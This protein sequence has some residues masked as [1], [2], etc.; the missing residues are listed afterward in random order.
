MGP[1]SKLSR[2]DVLASGLAIAALGP[3]SVADADVGGDA[4]HPRSLTS[5]GRGRPE[6]RSAGQ[7]RPEAMR[8]GQPLHGGW[9]QP[10]GGAGRGAASLRQM[11]DRALNLAHA[12]TGERL[13]ASYCRNGQY[14]GAAL[15][16]LSYFLRDWRQDAVVPIDPNVIDVMAL[17]QHA[18][19][20]GRPL[21]IL[22]GYRTPSTNEMLA[23]S[24]PDV[25]RNS[26]HLRG[27]AIDLTIPGAPTGNLWDLARSLGLGG[28]GYYP[29]QR[30]IHVDSG[31]VR[32]WQS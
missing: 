5:S 24:N 20:A 7:V 32:Y 25:A 17:I 15:S 9:S 1:G 10:G 18:A 4:R 3:A 27:M 8:S 26:Y 13:T 6:F 31:P 28:V 22:S 16:Q 30:F 29:A 14:D 23:R 11:P 12:Q 2:R 21:V 19:G